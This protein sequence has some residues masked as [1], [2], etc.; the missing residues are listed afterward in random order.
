M[1][2]L[3]NPVRTSSCFIALSALTPPILLQLIGPPNYT[4]ILAGLSRIL[5]AKLTHS[6]SYHLAS[7]NLVEEMHRML[8]NVLKTQ[9]NSTKWFSSLVF[10]VGKESRHQKESGFF[11]KRDY[12]RQA[13]KSLRS[14]LVGR[15]QPRALTQLLQ[16]TAHSTLELTLK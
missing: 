7:K 15:T 10:F 16:T 3:P 5:R 14:A 8:K 13:T 4:N 1:I 2:S 6:K 11:D 12:Y 9:E